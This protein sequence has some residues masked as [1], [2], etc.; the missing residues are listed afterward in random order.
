MKLIKLEILNLASLDNPNGETINF[1]EG[2]L[3]DCTIFSIVGSTGSGKSTILDAICL[4]LYGKT[5]RYPRNKGDKKGKIE[6]YGET[7]ND[8]N[9]RL[10]TT[11]CRNILTRGQN[12]GYSKLTFLANDGHLYRAE[13]NIHFNRIKFDDAITNLYRIKYQSDNSYTE[14]K[15]EW[16]SI[17]QIIGLDY[18]QFLRTVLLAQGSFANFLAA[19]ENDRYELLEKLVG[20]E[21]L[22]TAISNEI[23]A[24]K[25]A[26]EKHFVK[27]SA[28][29]ASDKQNIL[30]DV[31]LENLINEITRLET[32]QTRL[33]STLKQIE[34]ELKWY[35]DDKLKSEDIVKYL[36]D[37]EKAS[38][39]LKAIEE[40]I[41][42]LSRFDSVQPALDL[43]RDING[44]E[45]NIKSNNQT[46]TKKKEDE[47]AQKSDK[48]TKS[49][50]LDELKNIEKTAKEEQEK[51]API[52]AKARTIKGQITEAEKHL[53]DIQK[54]Q[55]EAQ[56]EKTTADNNL[57]QNKTN[58]ELNSN[59]IDSATKQFN[60]TNEQIQQQLDKLLNAQTTA[61]ENLKVERA[62]IEGI[63]ADK[64][65]HDKDSANQKFNYANDALNLVKQYLSDNTEK[66]AKEKE[67][68]QLEDENRRLTE[69]L[70]SLNIEELEQQYNTTRDAYTLITSENWAQHR[71]HLKTNEPCPLC[72]AIHHPYCEDTTKIESVS[73]SLKEQCDLIEQK[74]KEQKKNQTE[75]QTTKNTNDGKLS[76]LNDQLIKLHNSLAE[77]NN[78]WEQLR[79]A[80]SEIQSYSILDKASIESLIIQLQNELN[81]ADSALSDY[82]K[83]QKEI[84]RLQKLKDKAD[85][86]LSDYKTKS[87]EQLQTEQNS[88]DELK[89]KEVELTAATPILQ[90]QQKDK[91]EDLQTITQQLNKQ[92]KD[93]D[94]LKQQLKNMLQGKDPDKLEQELKT[95]TEQANRAVEAKEKE[96]QGIIELLK[97]L[98]GEL[99]TLQKQLTQDQN[100]LAQTNTSLTDWINL[101]NLSNPTITLDDI[102][103]ICNSDCDWDGIRKNKETLQNNKTSAATLLT[104]AQKEYEEHQVNKPQKAHEELLGEQ[105]SLK[106]QYDKD[107]LLEVDAKA[108]KKNHDDA[109]IALGSKA[110]ELEEATKTNN[111]WTAINESI[112]S[113]GKILRKI[114]QCYTL[115]FLVEYANAEIR[116]FNSRYEL[117]HVKN[118]L[119]IRVIDHDRADDIRDTTSLSGGETF[120]VSLGLALGLSALSSRNISFDN[121]FIDEGF[122]T[123]D[124]DALATVIDS[125]AMLQS[126]QGKKVCVISHTDTMSERITTQIRVIKTGSGSSRIQIHS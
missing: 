109:K 88:I 41:K 125:L 16:T 33:E 35:D 46:I 14:E 23:K 60:M 24:R 18:E 78:K 119:G 27:I 80:F 112:G 104:K 71:A 54:Q 30:P 8:K 110:E 38:A 2:V 93:L 94:S 115:S 76:S 83:T 3:K 122:G 26:A 114:A 61:E 98:E 87:D 43:L 7:D 106:Q 62:K 77:T 1:E 113:E 31:D 15:L 25:D 107:K 75:W 97:T 22:Y 68:Q 89:K 82:N 17:P 72:G 67:K 79:S 111:N 81:I 11:D 28:S 100:K 65:L 20:C 64:L 92:Q 56:N 105:E 44:L 86:A 66:E 58:I 103:A 10:A 53:K 99:T 55:Q 91:T 37:D 124:P 51:F 85:S 102:S 50:E 34:K 84:E 120:I 13:W 96:I 123:L 12:D 45:D 5:P 57:S 49:K 42:L 118:S 74:L 21:E 59:A 6:I 121:L 73:H 29:V 39:A 52:I 40:D 117:V 116:R 63:D 69:Q 9:N 19:N 32:S 4:A 101:Y 47:K 126:S 36:A 108:K 48:D 70:N 95:K 90:K